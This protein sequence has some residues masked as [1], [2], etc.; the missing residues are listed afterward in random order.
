MAQKRVIPKNSAKISFLDNSKH[1]LKSGKSQK[2]EKIWLSILRDVRKKSKKAAYKTARLALSTIT[3]ILDEKKI[4]RGKER[5]LIP[6]PIRW[7][8]AQKIAFKWFMNTQET[9]LRSKELSE[10]LLNINDQQKK[11]IEKADLWHE[12]IQKNSNF[13]RYRWY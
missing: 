9:N 5:Y 10:T 7:H 4:K 2:A 1:F 11:L 12:K 8:R 6:S 13:L 3:P